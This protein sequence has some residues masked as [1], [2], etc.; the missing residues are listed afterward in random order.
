[1]E[2]STFFESLISENKKITGKAG[3]VTGLMID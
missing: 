3:Y 1:M 2:I